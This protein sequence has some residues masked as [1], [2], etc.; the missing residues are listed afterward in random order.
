M[1]YLPAPPTA[2]AFSRSQSLALRA[3]SWAAPA[4]AA[5]AAI[6]RAAMSPRGDYQR[7]LLTMHMI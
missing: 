5:A 2:T 4:A 3:D 1:S 6:P 7:I